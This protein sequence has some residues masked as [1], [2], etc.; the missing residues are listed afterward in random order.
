LDAARQ[1]VAR[2]DVRA[3]AVRTDVADAKAVL[4]AADH[5]EDELGPIDAWINN[6][7]RHLKAAA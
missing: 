2:A 6:E 1:E 4:A 5:V 7:S 3:V